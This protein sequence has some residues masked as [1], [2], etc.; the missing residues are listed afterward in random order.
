MAG[1]DRAPHGGGA[2]EAAPAATQG[3]ARPARSPWPRFLMRRLGGVAVVL[4]VL[5]VATFLL[6][7]L[8]PGDPARQ[9]AGPDAT[10]RQIA[11]VEQR[12]GL[13]RPPLER[14]TSYVG[15]L[16]TGDLGTSFR[17]GQPV[18]EVIAGRL[19][20]TAQ[21]AL[22][23]VLA[24]LVIAVPLGMAV[25]VACRGGRRRRLDTLFSTATSVFGSTPEYIVGTA[26]VLVFAVW[27]GWL[28]AAGA[29]TVPSLLLPIAAV[30]LPPACHLSRIVRR[31]AAVVLE[32]DY[33]RTARG[34]RLG[35][36][37][38]YVRHALP[39]LLTSALTLGGLL[40]AGLLGGTVI[41]ESVF[42]WPGLGTLVVQA[43]LNRDYPVIQGIVLVIGLLATL[44]NLFVD[45][46]LGVLDPRSLHG[47]GEE[48][49]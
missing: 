15:G 14:F 38:L 48:A 17:T 42:A 20:F 4:A 21:L 26:L 40:L 49:R 47:R 10:P 29:A 19:P 1:Y 35:G 30:A 46:C 45:V 34:K 9:V 41:V 28:P 39:N 24:V 31:E 43:I 36:W 22:L 23:A 3:A 16:V 27:L 7:Q 8:V 6:V 5:V 12:L 18:L 25:A 32:Q 44:V 13:D 37:A 2:T 11:A 33:M